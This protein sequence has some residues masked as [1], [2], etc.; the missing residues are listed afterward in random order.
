MPS[1]LKALEKQILECDTELPDT[2]GVWVHRHP[3]TPGSKVPSMFPVGVHWRSTLK[4]HH[5]YGEDFDTET[6]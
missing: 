3:G 1:A 4:E 6:F 2:P 5:D